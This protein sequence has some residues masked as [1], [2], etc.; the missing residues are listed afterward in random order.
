[1]IA[2]QG[3]DIVLAGSNFQPVIT[4]AERRKGVRY[5]VA[6]ALGNLKQRPMRPHIYARY[7]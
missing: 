7:K 2:K 1:M 4:N 3:Y 5:I 6:T